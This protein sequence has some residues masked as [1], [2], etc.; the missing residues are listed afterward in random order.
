M[1][2]ATST[3]S[4]RVPLSGTVRTYFERAGY[5]YIEPDD[6]SSQVE[7]LLV[8]RR[9]LR[10]PHTS[11]TKGDRVTF[12]TEQ[13]PRGTLATDV[14]PEMEQIDQHPELSEGGVGY[15]AATHYDRG[16]G[17]IQLVDGR[18]PFF[19]LTYLEHPT[20]L[21]PLGAR[22]Q[23][24]VVTTHKG[25]QAR[26]IAIVSASF[27]DEV[28]QTLAQHTTPPTNLLAQAVLAR[29][30]KD[31]TRAR[32]LYEQGLRENPSLQ[33]ILSYAAM[34]KNLRRRLQAMA[35]Y[36]RGIALF[37]KTS[38]LYE[39]AGVLASTMGLA[40]RAIQLLTKALQLCRTT[41]QG[42]EKGVLLALA[43]IYYHRGDGAS[44]RDSITHYEE[45]RQTSGKK[46]P[47]NR[48]SNS[49]TLALNIA[50]IRLQHPRGELT[51]RFLTSCGFPIVQAQLHP[52]TTVGADLI[53]SVDNPELS[54][55]YGISGTVMV[56]C[57]FKSSFSRDDLVAIDKKIRSGSG[58]D[59]VS[60]HIIILVLAS[61]T[62]SLQRL[63]VNRIE[64]RS[65]R[66]PVVLPVSQETIEHEESAFAALRQTLERWLYRRDLFALNFPVIGRRF[67]GRARF[68]SEL[69][70]AI[71][72][73]TPVGVFGLRK[74]GKTS[75]LKETARRSNENGDIVAYLDLMRI[76]ADISN[77][78]WL[79]WKILNLLH[80]EVSAHQYID[81]RWRLGGKY[82][83]FLD[84]PADLAVATYFDSDLSEL[85]RR[86]EHAPI[87]PRPKVILL[88]DEIERLLPTRLGGPRLEGY[89]DFLGYLRGL[90]QETSA[91][92]VIVTGA[93]AAVSELSQFDGRDNPV[94]NFFREIYLQL[95]EEEE[96]DSMVRTIGRGMGLRFT[97][98]ATSLLFQMTGGH[99]FFTR[100]LCSFVA[101]QYHERPLEVTHA[102]VSGV[103]DDYVHLSGK[104]Y[105]EIMERLARDYPQEREACLQLAEFDD[106]I[107]FGRLGLDSTQDAMALRHLIGYQIVSF[108][109]GKV[110]L[111]ME[112]LRR[113]LRQR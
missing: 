11:L 14:H 64:D 8:N 46:G 15:I 85:L 93:N 25:L 27:P 30:S 61:V 6:E 5:G 83:D 55:S 62:E 94:F 96:C 28:A 67:F 72:T 18:Y 22:V 80:D 108:R 52:E 88:L 102:H 77:P 12:Y 84:V 66:A 79:Y 110:A 24:N 106:P 37:P 111:T 109:Q 17:F 101:S 13:I 31:Y 20:R 99:P 75:L 36:E 54:E 23:C 74:V 43:R 50:K 7:L 10:P 49:D 35:A 104:D 103:L 3:P 76:P 97:A 81:M 48:L 60:D 34:E 68:V 89:F 26:D 40:D 70:D 42:G 33:L 57:M 86:V 91:F 63:L 38:K 82:H 1:S 69:R 39:D 65:K 78:R 95:M 100:Q 53:L 41:T 21:P 9:S 90:C 4:D 112:L 59:V 87:S 32:K 107:D 92:A 58:G 16:F 19:H 113:W 45:A 56:R 2:S 44:L 105:R 47:G 73:G 71:S 51:Y 29:D 98:E